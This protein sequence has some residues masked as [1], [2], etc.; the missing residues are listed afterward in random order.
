MGARVQHVRLAGLCRYVAQVSSE[1]TDDQCRHG[2]SD[3]RS[4]K[5]LEGIAPIY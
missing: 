3:A 5:A 2:R 4:F 1:L